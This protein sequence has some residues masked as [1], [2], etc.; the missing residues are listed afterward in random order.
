VRCGNFSKQDEYFCQYRMSCHPLGTCMRPMKSE[1]Y[2]L[3][4]QTILESFGAQFVS[5]ARFARTSHQ[6]EHRVWTF[7]V[8]S[9]C[10]FWE[11]F[12]GLACCANFS[13]EDELFCQDRMSC[14]PFGKNDTC[15][16]LA[17][18]V[19]LASNIYYVY[20]SDTQ[21]PQRG[22]TPKATRIVVYKGHSEV[23]S[24]TQAVVC[25]REGVCRP[26]APG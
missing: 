22:C 11:L 17:Y 4:L 9:T 16:R 25:H 6:R 13:R 7:A 12:K 2:A 14:R 24:T 15:T 23:R 20:V 21:P 10:A 3:C 5:D 1:A 26:R 8:P 18:T 19:H